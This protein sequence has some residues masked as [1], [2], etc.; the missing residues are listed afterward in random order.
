MEEEIDLR[1]YINVLI[2]HWYWIAGLALVAA[3]TAF[4]VSSF[5][6]PT[7][8]ATAMVIIT[9]PRYLMQFDPRMQNLPFDPAQLA[10]GYPAMATSDELLL[11]AASSVEPPLPPERQGLEELRKMF[12]AEIAGDPNLIKLTARSKDPQEA[13]RLA[14][15]LAGQFV[16]HLNDISRRNG[17]L[18]LF[19]TQ[20]V[21]AKTVLEEADRALSAFRSQY[22]LGFSSGG[23]GDEMILELGIARRLQ[24]RTDLLVTYEARADRVA[25]LLGEARMAASQV[26]ANTSP[27][28]VAGLLADML[29]LGL[30]EG[31]TNPLVQINL[32]GL[33][34]EA[35]LSALIT[36]LGAKQSAIEE[37]VTRLTAE[38]EAL[39]AELADRQR[40]LDQLMR[41]RQVAQ[42]TYLTL[43]S[44]VQEARVEQEGEAGDIIQLLSRAAVPEE[45]ASP[46]RLL[47][48]VVAGALGLMVGVFGAFFI[49]Y[50]RGGD[51]F[52]TAPAGE[53]SSERASA[54]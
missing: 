52:E 47:N 49:E 16:D 19:E 2:R 29:Q 54:R 17:D 11:A 15:T 26:D 48:T 10:G 44:K 39:Q 30:V 1:E 7:Y 14:N 51:I 36:A 43:S 21:E 22:G 5:L 24:A 25:Q 40:E 31:E 34:A 38:V 9:Q 32:A 18:A 20:V 13:A 53:L 27:A 6:P 8:E 37:A 41:D 12:K 23:D 4:A 42:D 46:R 35:A 50:W 33:D 3:V 28:I 45:P